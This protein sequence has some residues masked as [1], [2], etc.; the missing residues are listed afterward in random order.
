M[1]M[2]KLDKTEWHA[3]FEHMS[4][5]LIGK[6]V[7]IQAASLALGAQ[8]EAE[9]LPLLGIV[10]DPKN[11]IVE[12]ALDGVD[13]VIHK[14]RDLYANLEAGELTSLEVIDGQDVRQIIILRDP[15]MLPAR[16]AARRKA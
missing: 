8:I 11:D 6:R 10:Y 4:K 3:F 1:A 2:R 5:G 16:P 12:V 13:H 14:P 7:E 9:W 15:L